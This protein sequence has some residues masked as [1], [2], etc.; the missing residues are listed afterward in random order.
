MHSETFSSLVSPLQYKMWWCVFRGEEGGMM[1]ESLLRDKMK[2][3]FTDFS[4]MSSIDFSTHLIAPLHRLT[5][6]IYI[7]ALLLN[8]KFICST[9]NST[10]FSFSFHMKV[11]KK[12]NYEIFDNLH[13]HIIIFGYH[14]IEINPLR[15][16]DSFQ[17]TLHHSKAN[18]RKNVFIL[19]RVNYV[20][21]RRWQR[22]RMWW[23][24]MR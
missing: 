7:W 17:F 13:H 23:Y 10:S 6:I 24:F 1:F 22:E 20:S 19:L 2:F 18:R 9:T 11:E 21:C 14:S 15:C 3:V 16:W 12:V 8:Q 4:L 5:K